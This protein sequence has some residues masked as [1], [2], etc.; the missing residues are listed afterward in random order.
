MKNVFKPYLIPCILLLGL[1]LFQGCNS[2]GDSKD[3]SSSKAESTTDTP[4]FKGKIALDVRDSEPDWGPYTDKKAPE[5]APNILFVLYDDTGLGAW[6]PYGGA[7][8]M[9]TMDRLA[10]N[11]LT[12]T[13]W[14][15]TALC[16]P[17]RS[18]ILTGRNHHLN[19]MAAITETADGFPGANGKVPASCVPFAQILQ[20]N[21]WSTFWLGKNHNVSETDIA[22][23]ATRAHWPTQNGWDRF[24]GFL[25]GETNNWYPD[26][27]EDN[28]FIEAPTTPEEGY[29]LSKDLAD[30]AITMLRNKNA[31]NPSKPFYL[32]FNPGANHAP[33]HSPAEYTAKYKGKFDQGYDAYREWVVERMKS[34]G[35]LPEDTDMVGFNPLPENIANPADYVRPWDQLNDDQKKLFAR[36]AEVYAGFSEYTD[37]QVGR[38]IDYLEETGQLENTIVLYA[39]D[40]GASGEGSP[41]GSVNENKFFNGYPDELEENLKYMDVLGGPDT[42]NHYPTGWAAAFSAP[43]KMFKRYSNYAGGT[44][45]PLVISWPKGIKAKGEIRHQ[46]H[47]SV[48]IVPTLLEACGIEMPKEYNGVKQTPLS[49]KSMLYTFDAEPNGKTQK[50]VQYYAMLGTRGVW[51]D[52]WKAVAVHAPLTGKGNFDK[53]EWELYHVDVDRSET[54][55]LAAEYPEKLEALKKEWFNQ[56]E[57]NKVLP[58]DDRSAAEILTIERPAEEEPKDRYIYYPGTAPVPEGVAVNIR[59][60]DYKILANVELDKKP[61]GVIF[62]HGSRF[63]GH[64]LFIKNNKLYYTYNFL[65]IEE[66]TFI[67][68][69]TLKPGK[70]T[71]GMEF[72]REK[73]GEHG[74]SLGQ[75][76][77]YINDQVVA[78]G[79]MK[80]QPA[81]FTLSGDGLCVGYDSGDTVSKHYK[82]PGEFEGGTIGGVAVS[83]EGEPYRNLEAEAR[84]MLMSH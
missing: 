52:G 33:H 50:D 82:S 36:M 14:H 19:G 28:H 68:N 80:T 45:D 6:S 62:A 63:G 53:D 16:S 69:T 27:V 56:A 46:Y 4:E 54:H 25:G 48:D 38:I 55:N 30:Q 17:T 24:Y 21:G 34:K 40:N 66:Q 81:K 76:K 60:R 31:S 51:K 26:L 29:H 22:P 61:S 74:E 39:A 10:A 8:N 47:H 77:L 5:G 75:M 78:E 65:G 72:T 64:S 2:A 18:T 11:G 37:A 7:I 1:S 3:P 84:R 41:D 73:A 43:F 79:P 23:G 9:P 71:L 83:V 44:N 32:W 49:G 57:I 15:T 35:I 59:G 12:Y 58:L 20:D 67:S 42:Y 13:Q 70:Y